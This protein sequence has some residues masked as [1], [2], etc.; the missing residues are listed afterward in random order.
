MYQLYRAAD[1]TSPP[2]PVIA[3]AGRTRGLTLIV[4]PK[5]RG[6]DWIAANGRVHDRIAATV[7]ESPDDQ[8]FFSRDSAEATALGPL[9]P[10][11]AIQET[12][13][14]PPAASTPSQPRMVSRKSRSEEHTS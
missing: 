13:F 4:R 14:G 5:G 7:S 9:S 1:R 11:W 12:T 2:A 3:Q 8:P 10:L 6:H